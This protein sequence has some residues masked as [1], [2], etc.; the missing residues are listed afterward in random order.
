MKEESFTALEDCSVMIPF[1]ISA[2]KAVDKH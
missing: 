1:K 2:P